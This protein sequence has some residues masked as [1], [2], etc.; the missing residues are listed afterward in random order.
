MA[1]FVKPNS[2]TKIALNS[3]IDKDSLN[4]FKRRYSKYGIDIDVDPWE[5]VVEMNS[6]NCDDE[7]VIKEAEFYFEEIV[8]PNTASRSYYAAALAHVANHF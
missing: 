1:C 3:T 2:S 6:M 4:D 7:E 8:S 5:E